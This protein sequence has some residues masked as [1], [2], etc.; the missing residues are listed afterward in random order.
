MTA[1]SGETSSPDGR[2]PNTVPPQSFF[3]LS[4]E[5]ITAMSDEDLRIFIDQYLGV[6][7]QSG[8]P[9]TVLLS[10]LDSVAVAARNI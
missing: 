2:R 4:D 6:R 1:A 7:V 5:Q 9:R 10:K 8:T 3:S